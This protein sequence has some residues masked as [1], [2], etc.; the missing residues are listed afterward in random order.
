MKNILLPFLGLVLLALAPDAP[1]AAPPSAGVLVLENENTMEGDIERVGEQYRV[2]RII[3]ETWVPAQQVLGVC[4][5]MEEAYALVRRRA[6]L[7]DADE[8]LRLARWCRVHGLHAQAVEELRGAVQLRPQHAEMR[9]MLAVLEQSQAAPPPPAPLRPEAV[10]GPAPEVTVTG[11]CLSLYATRV[12]PILMNACAHCH[13]PSAPGPFKLVR[14]YE[15]GLGN[16]HTVQQ[17]LA[18]VLA[19]VNFSQLQASPLLTKAISDHGKTG[20]APLRGRQAA[21]YRTLEEW[22]RLTLENNPQL[23]RPAGGQPSVAQNHAVFGEEARTSP[24]PAIKTVVA[25]TLATPTPAAPADETP[26]RV[27]PAPAP[28]RPADP[29]DPE[30]FNRM[31]HPAGPQTPGPA[32]P[33]GRPPGTN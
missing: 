23:Q 19:Q 16:R 24:P 13:T 14:C 10:A 27:K 29:F 33:P 7:R 22:V 15:Q 20:Q 25:R 30:E 8:R 1:V 9:R 17:N 3:G 6:N 26:A 28:A 21:A 32:G 12:Q 4:G 5:T 18:A 31:T 2:R 11:D